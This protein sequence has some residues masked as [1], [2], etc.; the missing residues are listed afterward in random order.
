MILIVVLI[1]HNINQTYQSTEE[2]SSFVH[3]P[4][5]EVYTKLVSVDTK[6]RHFLHQNQ[7]MLKDIFTTLREEYTTTYT[8]APTPKGT[9]LYNINLYF[10]F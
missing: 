2:I 10:M 6:L 7:A 5:P 3:K 1:V 8:S 9:I 4:Q